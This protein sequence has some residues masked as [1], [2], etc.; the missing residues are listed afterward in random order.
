VTYQNLLRIC[1]KL[2]C[3][4]HWYPPTPTYLACELHQHQPPRALCSGTTT[5]LH[6][7]HTSSPLTQTLICSLC[8]GYLE[9]Y[10]PASI[11]DSGTLATFK[12]AFKT[13][14]FNSAYTSRHWPPIGVCDSL[15]CDI[16]CQLNQFMLGLIDQSIYT[17]WGWVITPLYDFFAVFDLSPLTLTLMLQLG[18]I[19][20]PRCTF[21]PVALKP[22]GI[23]TKAS[24]TFPEYMWAK[25]CWK[26]FSDI[27][28]SI[29]NMAAGKWT[30]N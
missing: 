29:S 30:S 18:G 5:T 11:C 27:S 20:P 19:L 7:P 28:S 9:H 10:I 25:K 26:I 23:V 6:R 17:M 4:P 1:W 8:T 14:L 12:T 22:L 15:F 16:W 21:Y 3:H 2:L 24:V 13:H